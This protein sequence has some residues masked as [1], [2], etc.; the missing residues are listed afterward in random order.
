TA[1]PGDRVEVPEQALGRGLVV[2]RSDDERGVGARLARP[3]Y[4]LDGL[5]RVVRA[6]TG[7]HRDAAAPFLDAGAD[8][9]EM[10]VGGDGG[11]FAGGAAGN[12][13]WGAAL[14]LAACQRAQRCLV[15]GPVAE[16]GDQRDHGTAH[17]VH[18][19]LP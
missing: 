14:D 3:L 9:A 1:L 19:S 5:A 16:R 7:D 8:D 13:P 17:P 15:D 18:E 11:A 10:L 12:E 6:A 2:V 4:V